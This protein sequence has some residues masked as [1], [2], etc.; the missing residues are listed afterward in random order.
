MN[1]ARSLPR[2]ATW[3]GGWFRPARPCLVAILAGCLLAGAQA[4]AQTQAGGDPPPEP[5]PGIGVP[6]AG[7]ASVPEPK[8]EARGRTEPLVEELFGYPVHQVLAGLR[9]SWGPEFPGAEKNVTGLRDIWA[10]DVGRL[11]ISSGGGG[12]LLKA[13]GQA[14]EDDSEPGA[15]TGSASLSL[16]EGGDYGVKLGLRLFSGRKG[17]NDGDLAGVPGIRRTVLVRLSSRFTLPGDWDGQ[18]AMNS[19]MLEHGYGTEL[20]LSVGREWPLSPQTTMGLGIGVSFV[21]RTRMQALF[22]V[23]PGSEAADRLGVYLP[24]AGPQNL[25]AGLSLTHA[26][27]HNWIVFGGISMSGLLGRPSDSPFVSRPVMR[28]FTMGAAYRCC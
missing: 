3:R 5:P 11:R 22:G 10:I 24:G 4:A 28:S 16:I 14:S 9:F 2:G 17:T 8:A 21:D 12:G 15:D 23:P 26:V 13:L 27:D 20:T 18:I 7:A 6:P 1:A 25:S 19:D